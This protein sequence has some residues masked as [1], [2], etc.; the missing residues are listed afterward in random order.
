MSRRAYNR[1]IG[2][3]LLAGAAIFLLLLAGLGSDLLTRPP[4]T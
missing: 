4:V 2:A 3:I 1:L